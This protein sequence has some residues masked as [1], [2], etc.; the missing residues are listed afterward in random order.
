MKYLKINFLT[1]L[2]VLL[3]WNGTIPNESLTNKDVPQASYSFAIVPQFHSQSLFRIWNPILKELSKETGIKFKLTGNSSFVNF[4]KDLAEGK[5]D[6]AYVNPYH[7]V[8]AGKKQ[9]YEAILSDSKKQVQGIL[10][11]KR[12]ASSKVNQLKGKQVAFPSPNTLASSILMRSELKNK[13]KIQ[14]KPEYMKT[15]TD[16]YMKVYQ[17]NYQAGGGVES[18]FSKLSPRIKN[19]LKIVHRT[20]KIPSHPIIVSSEIPADIRKK[21]INAFIK[22]GKNPSTKALLQKIPV[23][24]MSKTSQSVYKNIMFTAGL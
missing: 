19:A 1:L 15:H 23:D 16:V 20:E 13:F 17:G 8:M 18:T 4:E 3:F 5:Y 22:M 6:F 7:A 10:V 2:S 24:N 14:V 21:V 11:V 9:K 12:D